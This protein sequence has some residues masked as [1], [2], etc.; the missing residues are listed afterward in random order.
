MKCA[1]HSLDS[2]P[3]R[4]VFTMPP[5]RESHSRKSTAPKRGKNNALR[6]GKTGSEGDKKN[7][8]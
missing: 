6:K 8:E 1:H 7:L 2:I 4:P 3:I 5:V